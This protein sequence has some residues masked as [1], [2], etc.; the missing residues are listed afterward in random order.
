MESSHVNHNAP[1]LLVKLESM[2]AEDSVP[3]RQQH[4]LTQ[5]GSNE[6]NTIIISFFIS[7]NIARQ[8]QQRHQRHK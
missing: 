2:K 6:A 7:H 8:E 1:V 4:C 5:Q 3:E